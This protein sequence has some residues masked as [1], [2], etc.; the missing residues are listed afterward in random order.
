MKETKSYGFGKT[1]GWVNDLWV[2][3]PL[4]TCYL[5]ASE[6]DRLS[7]VLTHEGQGRGGVSHRVC[8]MQD[9]KTIVLLVVFL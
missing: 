8:A 1:Q 5:W 2:N 6:D 9:N 4:K 3:Y 7:Q